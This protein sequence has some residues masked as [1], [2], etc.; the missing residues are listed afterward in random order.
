VL[1]RAGEPLDG[2]ELMRR[3]RAARRDRELLAGPAR[4]T[5]AFA[6]DRSCNGTDLVDGG[7]VW[8]E[9][10]RPVPPERIGIGVRIGLTV[11]REQPWRF[12]DTAS[13][14]LS[15]PW[16]GVRPPGSVAPR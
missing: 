3:R 4:W 13:G 14:F 16:N 12:V 2:V 15:R 7:D 8:I 9:R 10:G 1:L 5:Q 6:I 11:A